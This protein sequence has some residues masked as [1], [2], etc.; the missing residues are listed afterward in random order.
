M[1]I[2]QIEHNKLY[3][4]VNTEL[5]QK[6]IIIIFVEGLITGF[7]ALI[8]YGI[9][10]RFMSI[11]DYGEYNTSIGV[12]TIF[13][14]VCALGLPQIA[15]KLYRTNSNTVDNNK[16]LIRGFNKFVP[17]AIVLLTSIVF[18]LLLLIQFFINRSSIIEIENFSAILILLPI[19]CLNNFLLTC[20]AANG[21]GLEGNLIAGWGTQI[22]SIIVIAL[23]IFFTGKSLDVLK[24]AV[25]HGI[26]LVTQLIFLFKLQRSSEPL[27]FKKGPKNYQ[28]V[29]WLK[30]G[31]PFSLIAFGTSYFF[32]AGVIVMGLIFHSPKEAAILGLSAN[33][34]AV[35]ITT[36]TCVQSLFFP[37]LVEATSIKDKWETNL[38][39]N[40]WQKSWLIFAVPFFI[41]NIVFSKNILNLFDSTYISA[42]DTIFILLFGYFVFIF[43]QPYTTIYQFAGFTKNFILITYIFVATGIVGMIILGK[44]WGIKGV[45]LAGVFALNGRSFMAMYLAK[46]QINNW[47]N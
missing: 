42:L 13:T 43:F 20:C 15:T 28:I 23:S 31:I 34:A 38:I 40:K 25:L 22:L 1:L 3:Q 37:L 8:S 11:E 32:S 30:D 44:I 41:F 6:K 47:N 2:N 33:F 27:F 39:L 26:V 29:N 18:T 45:A 4:E 10:A 7:L 17:I 12:L 16:N 5:S 21:R 19:V 24:V 46:K 35:I 9:L 36:F 14:L